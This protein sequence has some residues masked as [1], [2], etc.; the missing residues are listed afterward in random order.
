VRRAEPGSP[1]RAPIIL[2]VIGLLFAVFGGREICKEKRRQA[3]DSP[4]S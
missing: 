2:V 4:P 1:V 3:H